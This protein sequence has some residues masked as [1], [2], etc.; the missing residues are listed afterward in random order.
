MSR[1]STRALFTESSECFALDSC[2]FCG[3]GMLLFADSE[4]E[5]SV[6]LITLLL[7]VPFLGLLFVMRAIVDACVDWESREAGSKGGA[8]YST[9]DWAGDSFSLELLYESVWCLLSWFCA[10]SSVS[11]NGANS[12]LMSP[13]SEDASG[14]GVVGFLPRV[15]IPGVVPLP[16]VLLLLR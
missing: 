3:D 14:V 15:V 8:C 2:E 13:S 1:A 16:C 11:V 9:G 10:G 4:F 5:L 6:S 7:S 12:A